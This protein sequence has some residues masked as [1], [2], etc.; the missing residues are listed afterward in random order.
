MI[1]FV[2]KRLQVFVSSTY[3]DLRDERQAAVEAILVAG[4]IPAGMELFTSGDESQMEAI[5]QWIDESDVYLLILGGR[6][7]S[8]EP[9]TRKSYTRL[10]YEYALSIGKPMFSCVVTDCALEDR[11]RRLGSQALETTDPAGLKEFRGVVLTKL[12]RFWDDAKDIKISVGETLAQ[13]SRRDDLIGWVRPTETSADAVGLADE[14]ARL[15][16]ENAQLRNSQTNPS[17]PPILGFTVSELIELLKHKSLLDFLIRSRNE[18]AS[19]YGCPDYG[20]ICDQLKF[21]GLVEPVG[22]SDYHFKLT[23]EGR[24]FMNRLDLVHLREIHTNRRQVPP[25]IKIQKTGAEEP[26][27]PKHRPASDLER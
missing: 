19:E 24:F 9:T 14:I 4:H 6:Y 12:V 25:N 21:I 27:I 11:V 17:E 2:R 8:I 1:H 5:K 26:A 16:K 18:L 22:A 20:L 3:S 10:E 13:L 7:G 15:S 23:S